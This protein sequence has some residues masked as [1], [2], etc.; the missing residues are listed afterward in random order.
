MEQPLINNQ[1]FR[2]EMQKLDILDL[3]KLRRSNK[4]P[5]G[6]SCIND[7]NINEL[8]SLIFKNIYIIHPD[9]LVFQNDEVT[10][11][12]YHEFQC[13]EDVQIN[14]VCGDLKDLIGKPILLAEKRTEDI[15]EEYA[16]TKYTFYE[17]ANIN[18]NI[19]VRWHGTSNGSYSVEVDL[20]RVNLK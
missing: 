14:D 20:L 3:L 6:F 13:C 10:F 9:I 12:F 17:F 7:P 1:T 19:T 15:E 8:V 4:T 16:L 18:G 11:I 5:Y 2:S